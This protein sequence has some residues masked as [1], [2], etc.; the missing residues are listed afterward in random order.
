MTQVTAQI[1][2]A[3]LDDEDLDSSSPVK[4]ASIASELAKLRSHALRVAEMQSMPPTDYERLM[5]D[6]PERPT[7]VVASPRAGSVMVSPR[8]TRT[9]LDI[10]GRRLSAADLAFGQALRQF[11][12]TPRVS[13]CTAFRSAL[14]LRRRIGFFRE[15]E[16]NHLRGLSVRGRA[17]FTCGGGVKQPAAVT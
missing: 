12:L 10:K 17:L 15:R 7:R 9:A 1:W 5:Q 2:R 16:E 3:A 4:T 8:G 14:W 13:T 11:V 6:Y